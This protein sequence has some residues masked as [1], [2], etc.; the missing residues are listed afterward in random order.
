[1][2]DIHD[3]IARPY[4]QIQL[5]KYKTDQKTGIK[6]KDEAKKI[7]AKNIDKLRELQDQ[8]FAQKRYGV[9]LIFQGMDASGKDSTIKHVISGVNPQ[10][11][12][13]NSFAAP[14]SQELKHD[15]LWRTYRV[16]PE[17]GMIGIFNRS[18]Y[19]EV[20]TTR[21]HPEFLL[22]QKLPGI[23]TPEDIDLQFWE[24]R[25]RSINSMEKHLHLNGT[26]I[27]KFYLNLSRREQKKRLL[28]RIRKEEKNWKFD[29]SDIRERS[30][31][32]QYADA[33]EKTINHTSTPQAP[34][35]IIPADHK[36]YMRTVVS[37]ILVKEL[38]NL[39]IRYPLVTTQQSENIET[40]RRILENEN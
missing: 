36:W 7:R 35:Y 33:F 10:G 30:H 12:K 13:V 27:L 24:N 15:F 4:T 39:N 17:K 31:W 38:E 28:K 8:M 21:V 32:Q 19:E 23:F 2:F 18:Y 6:D 20:I 34:W 37:Q 1:M 11:C 5:K 26:L 22:K 16:L 29:M 40:A 9:L 25:F 3:F 14:S